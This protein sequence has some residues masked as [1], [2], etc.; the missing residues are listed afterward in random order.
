MYQMSRQKSRNLSRTLSEL[1]TRGRWSRGG[2][3]LIWCMIK[4]RK[5]QSSRWSRGR[6]S[7]RR[8][9]PSGRKMGSTWLKRLI[10]LRRHK[11][12]WISTFSL[13]LCTTGKRSSPKVWVVSTSFRSLSPTRGSRGAVS[14]GRRSLSTSRRDCMRPRRMDPWLWKVFC[15]SWSTIII[16]MR[17][18]FRGISSR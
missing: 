15:K 2:L 17:S 6:T 12:N 7:L 4:S 16:I 5:R 18:C 13:K 3:P 11:N 8:R 9:I 10:S 14:M 1:R